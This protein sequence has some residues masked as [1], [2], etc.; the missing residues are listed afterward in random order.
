VALAVITPEREESNH[1]ISGAVLV[2]PPQPKSGI[3]RLVVVARERRKFLAP[4]HR[5]E[6]RGAEM[7][8]SPRAY[9]AVP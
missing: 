2:R 6:L 9:S 7:L 4:L 8:M 1:G 5:P 3:E